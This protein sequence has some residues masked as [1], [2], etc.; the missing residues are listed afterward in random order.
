MK[1]RWIASTEDSYWRSETPAAGKAGAVNLRLT[2]A[3]DQQMEG[4]G[5]CFNEMGWDAL[6]QLPPGK[7][8]EVMAAL[9][10]PQ[11]EG[12]RFN[13][14]RVPIGASDYAMEW[15]DLSP[16]ADDWAMEH[17]TIRRDES[18]LLPYIRSAM[19][20]REDLWLHASPWSP[21][22]WMKTRRVCNSGVL[23]W[24]SDVLQAYAKYLLSFV[25]AY[26]AAGV[27][28]RQLHVQNEPLADQKFPSCCWSGQHLAKFIG[29][30]LGP[31]FAAEGEPCDIFLGT[32]NTSDY[33]GYVLPT[34]CDERTRSFV[35]GVGVQWEGKNMA[36][37]IHR[38]WPDVR[39]AQTENECCDGANT[40]A[41]ALY[42][43]TLMWRYI[44]NGASIY[45]YWNMVLPPGGVSSWGWPQN[46]MITA[47]PAA[48]T[49]AYNPDFHAMKHLSQFVAPGAVRL[50]LTGEWAAN[51]LAFRNPG[52]EVVLLAANALDRPR[53][54]VFDADGGTFAATAEPGSLNTFVVP[55]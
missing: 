39:I 13:H 31:L 1:T 12:C 10:D 21:P 16:A 9:F 5:G 11:A 42:M 50:E 6:R 23:R 20:H 46:A 27:D 15:Y 3:G 22:T 41:E 48:G 19:K 53:E 40:W 25:R 24:E 55:A 52:G 7:V 38:A 45:T 14:G 18:C 33:E 49:V 36:G 4:F 26:R 34:L 47:D 51:A 37:H 17:F 35:A 29:D 28:V 43:F 8:E 2:G 44:A 30:Y 32:L 54:L